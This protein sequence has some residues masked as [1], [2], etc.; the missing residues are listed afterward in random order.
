MLFIREFLFQGTLGVLQML[1][2]FNQVP[3]LQFEIGQ[4]FSKLGNI[5]AI[6]RHE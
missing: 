5:Q 1:N 2:Q 4:R 6:I 3:V